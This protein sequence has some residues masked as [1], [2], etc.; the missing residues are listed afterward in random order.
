MS[1]S[2]SSATGSNTDDSGFFSV[3]WTPAQPY[4]W[5]F[6]KSLQD[7]NPFHIDPARTKLFNP[8]VVVEGNT[9]SGVMEMAEKGFGTTPEVT[10]TLHC[11]TQDLSLAREE[12]IGDPRTSSGYRV[13]LASVTENRAGFIWG[14][15]GGLTVYS[16]LTLE[17]KWATKA[18]GD[19]RSE[20]M[21][22]IARRPSDYP[23]NAINVA[24]GGFIGGTAFDFVRWMRKLPLRAVSLPGSLAFWL[25]ALSASP[26][27]KAIGKELEDMLL[28]QVKNHP[29]FAAPAAA[30]TGDE[31]KKK[32]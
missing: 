32:K 23:V 26:D 28:E 14:N 22:L 16:M 2:S 25:L 20:P 18:A 24:L 8:A 29:R 9:V 13:R 10:G 5:T 11:A 3:K 31:K 7:F 17:P 6:P 12:T 30:T 21:Y 15:M 4:L 1:S 27:P 19:E